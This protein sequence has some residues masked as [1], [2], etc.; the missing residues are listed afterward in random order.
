MRQF[1]RSVACQILLL[2]FAVRSAVAREV[3]SPPGM[4]GDTNLAPMIRADGS[5]LGLGRPPWI[6]RA[7]HWK[8][9][10]S[11][12]AEKQ[13]PRPIRAHETTSQ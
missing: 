2:S 11:Y 6:W 7:Q 3:P 1:G 10:A 13:P 12:T 4:A 8:D 9:V 5:L